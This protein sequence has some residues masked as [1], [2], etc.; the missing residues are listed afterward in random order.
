MFSHCDMK[1]DFWILPWIESEIFC[2]KTVFVACSLFS[3]E[4]TNSEFWNTYEQATR[5]ALIP[6]ISIGRQSLEQRKILKERAFMM[7]SFSVNPM[8]S[9]SK[10][11]LL[12][13]SKRPKPLGNS[14]NV[15]GYDT[16][17]LKIS[18]HYSV[19]NVFWAFKFRHIVQSFDC[20][21]RVSP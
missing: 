18:G 21:M 3:Y 6:I 11:Y 10:N 8:D 20:F 1:Q 4:C 13:R 17:L 19:S 16:A 14:N 12:L 5:T 9:L 15:F 7:F 2:L